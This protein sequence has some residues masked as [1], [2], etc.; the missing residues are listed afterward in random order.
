ML[1]FLTI[2]LSL[3]FLVKSAGVFVG[4]ASS[5]AK[6]LRVNEFLIGFTVVAIGPKLTEQK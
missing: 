3:F 5:L 1:V 2:V 4:Q 6:K